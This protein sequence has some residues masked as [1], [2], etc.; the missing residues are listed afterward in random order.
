MQVKGL[1][2]QH[3]YT[4]LKV[5]K[6]LSRLFVWFFFFAPAG[7]AGSGQVEEAAGLRSLIYGH[8]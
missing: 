7:Q 5:N 1:H 6:H 8:S 2:Q 3:R 4:G